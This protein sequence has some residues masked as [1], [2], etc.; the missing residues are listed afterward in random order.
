MIAYIAIMSYAR[1]KD[2]ELYCDAVTLAQV[3]NADLALKRLCEF[4]AEDQIRSYLAQRYD[5]AKPYGE[6][7][8]TSVYSFTTTYYA[9]SRVY[10]DATAYSASSTYALN[11]LV[12]QAGNVYINTTPILVAEAFTISKWGLLGT[13]YELFYVTTPADQWNFQKAYIAGNIIYYRNKTYTAVL[14]STNIAPDSQYGS[15][16]WG[17]GTAFA[18]GSAIPTN[19]LVWTSGDNRNNY[20]LQLYITIVVYNMFM[21]IAPKNIQQVRVNQ[22]EMAITWLENAG[23]GLVTAELPLLVPEQGSSIRWGSI[24]K[25]NNIY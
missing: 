4:A 12:L 11:S 18:V 2:Y 21:K 1:S 23:K 16:Y 5:F 24:D 22:Y 19:T 10:L 6:F 9:N 15:T 8:D 13:Q 7:T 17:T 25:N 20:L 14:T 3:V